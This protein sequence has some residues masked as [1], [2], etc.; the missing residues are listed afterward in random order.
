VLNFL[1]GF[2]GQGNKLMIFMETTFYTMPMA[3]LCHP[4]SRAGSPSPSTHPLLMVGGLQQQAST[5]AS[6]SRVRRAIV[7][8]SKCR[9]LAERLVDAGKTGS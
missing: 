1:L 2:F 8:P 9:L 7:H 6:L 5:A 4:P 3:S